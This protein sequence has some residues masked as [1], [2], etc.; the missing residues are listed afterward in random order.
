[1]KHMSVLKTAGFDPNALPLTNF[2]RRLSVGFRSCDDAS[3]PFHP[4]AG[5]NRRFRTSPVAGLKSRHGTQVCADRHEERHRVT[6]HRCVGPTRARTSEAR[7]GAGLRHA[8]HLDAPGLGNGPI[9]SGL[10]VGQ[11][12]HGQPEV[13]HVQ[14]QGP[15]P[16]HPPRTVPGAQPHPEHRLRPG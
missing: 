11:L 6:L 5:G 12:V 16:P 9:A 15:V 3:Q 10:A 8:D 2:W 13:L 14:D 7:P 4:F 1:M